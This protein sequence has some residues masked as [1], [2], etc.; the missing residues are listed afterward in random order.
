MQQKSTKILSDITVYMKYARY[1]SKENR[2]ETWKEIVERNMQM[3]IKKFPFLE[4]EIRENYEYVFDKKVLPSMRALQFSGKPIEISPNRIFNCAYLPIDHVDAFSETMFL[5]LGGTGIGFSVQK[6]HVEKL[7]IV[8]GVIKPK[9]AR[10]RKKRYLIGD[11]IEGWA[12]A[13]KVLVE[14]YF[15]GR[16]EVEFDFRDIRVKGARLITSGGKAPGP[17]PL[18]DCL[19][20]ITKIFETALE[21][22]GVG[23]KLRPIELHDM[24]CFIAD[25]VLSGGIRRAALISFFSLSDEEMLSSKF[26]KWYELN[27]QRGRANN[28]AVVV[29][30]RVKKKDFFEFWEKIKASGSGEPGIFFTNDKDCLS[31]PC[32]EISLR[33]NQFCNLVSINASDVETQED[34]NNRTVVASFIGTLQASYTSFHYLR[35][36]WQETTEKEALLGVSMTGIASKKVLNLDLK[37]AAKIAKEVNEKVADAISIKKAARITCIKPEGTAS[38]VLGTSSGIHAWHN[39]YYIRRLRVGKNEPIYTYLMINHP[40]L[41]EDEYFK[42]E[43]QAIISIPV[44]APDNAILRN[45]PAINLLERAKKFSIEWIINGHRKGSNTH[46][47][48]ITVSVK[49]NEWEKVGEWMWENRSFYNGITVIPY[50]GG[51]YIQSPFEDCSKEIYEKMSKKLKFINLKNVFEND[52]NTNLAGEIACAGNNC[53]IV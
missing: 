40:E 8:L 32:C 28:S 17:Q 12:D 47:V 7:P 46:N 4:E 33:A 45:E 13:I 5:L 18:K 11:S 30:H 37:E 44:K 9:D 51:S 22:R 38:L 26:G 14:S 23:T 6:H 34:L 35:D 53:T 15:F 41:I 48:S 50:N 29:R 36:V 20:N 25:A 52:D 2:R 43:S 16:K 39:D 1:L 10:E 49:D 27:P 3:H 19:H 42:P 31:N 24:Q 21:E